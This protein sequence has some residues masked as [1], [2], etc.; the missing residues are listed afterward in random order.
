MGGWIATNC[1]V[2]SSQPLMFSSCVCLFSLLWYIPLRITHLNKKVKCYFCNNVKG[3]TSIC[4]GPHYSNCCKL[5]VILLPLLIFPLSQSVCGSKLKIS[6]YIL[7]IERKKK[8]QKSSEKNKLKCTLEHKN[9][10]KSLIGWW[11][12]YF[13]KQNVKDISG[14]AKAGNT[15]QHCNDLVITLNLCNLSTNI[16]RQK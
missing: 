9:S 15:F 7:S 12:M 5:L 16:K 3:N 11:Y 10:L 6:S 1:Q 14:Y 13:T 2:N 8:R 4:H